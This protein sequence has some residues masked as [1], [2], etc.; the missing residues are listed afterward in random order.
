MRFVFIADLHLSRYGQ[1]K[2]E[3]TTQLPERLYSITMAVNNVIEYCRQNDIKKIVIGGDCLHGKSVI[4]ALAQSIL[5]DFFRNNK[6]IDFI[7]IDGNHD[8]S[9]KGNDAISALKSID[10]EPNVTR[11]NQD[12]FYDIA[13]DIL[14]VPYSYNMV[15]IIKKNKAKY[16]ISH[17]GLNEGM[18]NSGI[19]IVADISLTKLIGKYD[20]VLLG[21]YHKPQE[22]I[23]DN[24]EVYYVGSLIQLDWGE[25]NEKKRF[26]VVDTD[27]NTIQS[28]LSSGYKKYIEYKITNENKDEIIKQATKDTEQGD[29]VKIIKESAI[30]TDDIPGDL[31]IVDKVEKDITNRGLTNEMSEADKFKRYLTIKEIPED[32]HQQYLDV[33]NRIVE[34]CS[35][36]EAS[37]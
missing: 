10:N 12:K 19:S 6:D 21:H 5:L 34:K 13:E 4:Y 31:R 36:R 7:V 15:D 24:I 30:D 29:Y 22:I 20:T 32:K 14:Y 25:K 3:D 18:L 17:F 16:L 8:L 35:S 27:L 23:L 28:V 37:K 9:G 33:A 1:D 2:I 11:I 26:L